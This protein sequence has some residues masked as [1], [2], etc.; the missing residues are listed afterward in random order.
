MS[1]SKHA[2]IKKAE[3]TLSNDGSIDVT[4]LA[5][6]MNISVYGYAFDDNL[7]GA[8]TKPEDGTVAIYINDKDPLTRQRFS[9][10]HELAHY[11][12][13][14]DI[15]D[16]EGIIHRDKYDKSKRE[17]EANRFAEEILMPE[18]LVKS[19]LEDQDVSFETTITARIIDALSRKFKVSNY[20]AIIR[21]RNLSYN[22]PYI[23]YA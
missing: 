13:H 22:V 11:V 16:K 15:L 3:N 19:Y 4:K 23:Y 6:D 7:S 9:I 8:V 14:Q 18:K 10:A 2:I 20:V 12:L 21:L 5:N 17:E 1:Y